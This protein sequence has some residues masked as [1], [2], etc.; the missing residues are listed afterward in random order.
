MITKGRPFVS[1]CSSVIVRVA[2]KSVARALPIL[3]LVLFAAVIA[4]WVWARD[5]RVPGSSATSP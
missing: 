3:G 1:C 5:A 2:G 4:P